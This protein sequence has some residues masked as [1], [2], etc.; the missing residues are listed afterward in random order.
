MDLMI[1]VAIY[2]VR[3]CRTPVIMPRPLPRT[4]FCA[5]RVIIASTQRIAVGAVYSTLTQ[6]KCPAHAPIVDAASTLAAYVWAPRKET[7]GCR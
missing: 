1:Q 2:V 5:R 6:M 7:M 3:G 4:I